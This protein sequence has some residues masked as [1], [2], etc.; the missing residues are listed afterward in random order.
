VVDYIKRQPKAD[1][2]RLVEALEQIELHGLEARRVRFRQVR[3]KRWEIKVEARRSH[4]VFYASLE[5]EEIVLLHAYPKKSQK[6]PTK[7]INVAERRM[8]EII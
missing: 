6:A 8:R 3:G 4:R 1:R 2:A 5:G 7:E